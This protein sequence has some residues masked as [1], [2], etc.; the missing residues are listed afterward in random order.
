MIYVHQHISPPPR[1]SR[2]KGRSLKLKSVKFYIFDSVLY[3]KDLGGVLL[4]F[5]V[6]DEA[7]QVMKDFHIGYCGGH[8]FWK[9]IAN[10]LLRVGYYLPSLF[11][12]FYK[13]VISYHQCQVF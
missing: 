13:T 12:D 6:E 5:F 11:L 3:W 2:S 7:Q 9:T 4:N 8:L 1:M 10:K